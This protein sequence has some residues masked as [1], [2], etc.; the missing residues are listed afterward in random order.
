MPVM[1]NE[2]EFRE[3]ISEL[4]DVACRFVGSAIAEGASRVQ[5]N[6]RNSVVL[7]MGMPIVNCKERRRMIRGTHAS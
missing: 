6:P 2:P 5:L 3:Y 1:H 7:D 4:A